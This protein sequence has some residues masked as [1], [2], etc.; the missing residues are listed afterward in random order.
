MTGGVVSLSDFRGLI[1]QEIGS[2]DWLQ[3]DQATIDAFA[4]CTRDFQFIH[5]DPVR[6]ADTAFGGTIA[7]GFLTLSLLSALAQEVLPTVE[8]TAMV[9]NFGFNKIRFISPVPVGSRIRGRFT[10]QS[11]TERRPGEWQQVLEAVIEIEGGRRLAL[12]AEWL[13]LV[14]FNPGP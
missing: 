12:A 11:F 3:I 5:V 7:H 10:L 2:S 8:G 14:V 4:T 1:A 6:A 9:M 13:A